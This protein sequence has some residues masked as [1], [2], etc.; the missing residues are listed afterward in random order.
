[1]KK[2][3]TKWNCS[4]QTRLDDN[5]AEDLKVTQNRIKMTRSLPSELKV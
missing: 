2:L 3:C 5:F 4:Q 1:M